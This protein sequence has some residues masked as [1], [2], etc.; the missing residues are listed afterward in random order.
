[1]NDT[2]KTEAAATHSF[3]EQMLE[4]YKNMGVIMTFRPGKK[5]IL[6]CSGIFIRTTTIFINDGVKL[7]TGLST[8]SLW[9]TKRF[10]M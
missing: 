3:Y 9:W 7:P 6:L 10:S 5:F 4:A 1:M 8:I 2:A